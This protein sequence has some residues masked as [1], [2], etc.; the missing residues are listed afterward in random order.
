VPE[1]QAGNLSKGAVGSQQE[2]IEGM[3][4]YD[5]TTEKLEEEMRKLGTPT[6]GHVNSS[7]FAQDHPALSDSGD[8]PSDSQA[9]KSSGQEHDQHDEGQSRADYLD[10]P[11]PESLAQAVESVVSF[12]A[13]ADART[14]LGN[15]IRIMKV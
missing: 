3:G 2:G 9:G 4:H 5:D 14:A 12:A 15:V 11:L 10:D 1:Q 13:P 8:V 6:G 7:P